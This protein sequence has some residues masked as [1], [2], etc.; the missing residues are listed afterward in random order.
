MGNEK[1]I[2]EGRPTKLVRVTASVEFTAYVFA[3]Y[4]ED[5]ITVEHPTVPADHVPMAQ[6]I[7]GEIADAVEW[8]APLGPASHDTSAMLAMATPVK[9]EVT[10]CE[11]VE[12][13]E[14]ADVSSAV[15]SF[16]YGY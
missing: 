13:E 3:D 10:S 14:W 16:G 15:D 1:M 9:A 5:V 2:W 12:V 4:P 7:A 6:V 11:E 8:H